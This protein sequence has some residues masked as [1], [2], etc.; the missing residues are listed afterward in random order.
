M[1]VLSMLAGEELLW[2][3]LPPIVVLRRIDSGE[4]P[5]VRSGLEPFFGTGGASSSISERASRDFDPE[6]FGKRNTTEVLEIV[7]PV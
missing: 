2:R 3:S 1:T 6:I 7:V 4:I 5:D